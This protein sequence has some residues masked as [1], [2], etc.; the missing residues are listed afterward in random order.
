[1]ENKQTV[2]LVNNLGEAA[3]LRTL[4]HEVAGLRLNPNNKVR[5]QTQYIFNL[6]PDINQQ[7][8]DYWKGTLNIG[9]LTFYGAVNE[10]RKQRYDFEQSLLTGDE[11]LDNLQQS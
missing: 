3:A 9:A 6:T 8:D 1:M 4:G 10:L 7:I 2:V 11:N 5:R